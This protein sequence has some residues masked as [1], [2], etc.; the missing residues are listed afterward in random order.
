MTVYGG[1][2]GRE[3]RRLEVF[4]ERGIVEVTS[5]VLVDTEDNSFRMEI[6]GETTVRIDPNVILWEHLAALGVSVQPF[7]WNE[8][9]SRAFFE[10]IQTGRPASPGFA[11]ALI[12]HATVEAAY[13][14]AK[15]K[16]AVDISE[17]IKC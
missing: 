6:A 5:G 4:F 2:Q 10:S 16:R 15:Y 8:L 11:D 3:E 13:Q 12:A 7:F 9:A 1:V 14:S 17:L